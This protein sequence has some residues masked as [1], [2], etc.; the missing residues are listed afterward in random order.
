MR[1]IGGRLKGRRLASVRGS[2]RPTADR[3]REAVFNI[4]GETVVAAQVLDLFAGT[5]ALGIEALSRGAASVVFVEDDPA[6]LRVLR[7]NLDLCGLTG[8][9]RVYPLAVQKAL[10]LLAAQGRRFNLIFLD[11]PYARGWTGRT[12][13][14][15]ARLSLLADP[16][17]IVAEHSRTE[18]M[19][20]SCDALTC[21]DRRYYGGTAI[22]FYTATGPSPQPETPAPSVSCSDPEQDGPGQENT[23]PGT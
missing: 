2:M 22:S 7:T 11:P 15:L 8:V 19:A 10:P 4:L 21:L 13:V 5:G 20:A 16:G 12:L 17:L 14:L 9:S 6:S 1:I 23:P 3:V 18:A